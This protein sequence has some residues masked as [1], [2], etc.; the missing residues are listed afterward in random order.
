MK[1]ASI[2]ITAVLC[3]ALVICFVQIADLKNQLVNEQMNLNAQINSMRSEYNNKIADLYN[4]LAEEESLLSECSFEIVGFDT[5][6]YKADILCTV[7]L[8]EFDSHGT[9]VKITLNDT[10]YEMKR[11][12]NVFT[13]H[14]H[15]P[16]F[17]E[18]V[19]KRIAITEGLTVKTVSVNEYVSSVYDLLP[20]VQVSISGAVTK[21]DT[22]DGKMKFTFNNDLNVNIDR[23]QHA[24]FEDEIELVE[25]A[26]YVNGVCVSREPIS[27]DPYHEQQAAGAIGNA[28]APAMP[29]EADEGHWYMDVSK[30]AEL[31]LTDACE[32]RVEAKDSIGLTYSTL[33]V[34][35]RAGNDY[36]TLL[37]GWNGGPVITDA[38]GTVLYDLN[39]DIIYNG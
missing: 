21:K 33:I 6:T 14:A 15:V 17:G 23:K 20:A 11:E 19:A 30:D 9:D 25:L 28:V 31:S 34:V 32:L 35:K 39:G 2:V 37:D 12:G 10:E 7:A 18:T 5:E 27:A 36:F 26:E 29:T 4:Q 1:K 3:I 13:A 16:V 22:D 24:F 8:K 38:A